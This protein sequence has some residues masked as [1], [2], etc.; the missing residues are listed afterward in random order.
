[1]TVNCIGVMIPSE[2]PYLNSGLIIGLLQ[3][4]RGGAE[5]EYLIGHP[6]VGLT[7]MDAFTLGHYMLIVFIIIGNIGYLGYVR[8]KQMEVGG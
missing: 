1:M 3:S 6:G 7:A 8:R 4:M 5:L 2:M